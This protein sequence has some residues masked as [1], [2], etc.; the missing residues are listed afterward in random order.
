MDGAMRGIEEATGQSNF[1]VQ[2]EAEADG[3][4]YVGAWLNDPLVNG[5]YFILHDYRVVLGP[6]IEFDVN[7][8]TALGV[9]VEIQAA[10]TRQTVPQVRQQQ[11]NPP[12]PNVGGID[13]LYDNGMEAE[14]AQAVVN[15]LSDYF[16]THELNGQ[17]VAAIDILPVT[18]Q[19]V[20]GLV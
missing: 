3:W 10:A 12:P 16:A 8:M 20:C 17:M 14:T 2:I 11:Q 13:N 7:L 4:M 15:D 18:G 5:A 9:P 1:T 19:V 6:N